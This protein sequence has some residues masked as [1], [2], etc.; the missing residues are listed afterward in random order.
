MLESK[1]K[2]PDGCFY[3]GLLAFLTVCK[4][5]PCEGEGNEMHDLGL[6]D[7]METY[8]GVRLPPSRELLVS[9]GGSLT[10]G[11]YRQGFHMITDYEK[12]ERNFTCVGDIVDVKKKA[13]IEKNEKFWGFSFLHYTG[14]DS[15]YTTFVNILPLTNRTFDKRN[16]VLTGNER[17]NEQQQQQQRQ[18][19]LSQ[20]Q[21]KATTKQRNPATNNSNGPRAQKISRRSSNKSGTRPME[22]SQPEK[23]EQSEQPPPPVADATKART[24]ASSQ[25]TTLMTADQVLAC[26]DEQQFYTNSLRGYGNILTSM[27]IEISRNN[28]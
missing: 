11:E 21:T 7:C 14:P 18:Q 13:M 10:I 27:G 5:N 3:L 23:P 16:L 20:S 9:F 19:T 22:I 8:Q 28:E 25:N 12:I 6:C 15:S 24:K 4:G 1:K 2:L 26:N 17:G